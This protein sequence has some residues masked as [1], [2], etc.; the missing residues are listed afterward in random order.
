MFFINKCELHG[1]ALFIP[2][3]PVPMG[4]TERARQTLPL[5]LEVQMS[6][7]PN[8][9]L[10][11]FN[12]GEPV[13]VGAHFGPYEGDLVDR[14]EAINSGYSW[15]I[16]RSTGCEEYIDG[17]RE[18]CSN[19]MRYV[20]CARNGENH[21]LVAFQYLGGI[22]YRCCRPI[23]PGQELL[24]W[25]EEEY[26]RRLGLVFDYFWNI[27]SSANGYVHKKFLLFIKL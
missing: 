11:V 20:N 15:V 6:G 17:K 25:Y 5:G 4:C 1:P 9:G 23:N 14:E 22:L 19:W 3:T 26:A 8:A 7:I 13:P 24:V 27:K 16:Y 10:G 2:D 12:K 21:N 18:L